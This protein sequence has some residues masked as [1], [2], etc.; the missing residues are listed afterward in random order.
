MDIRK[1]NKYLVFES[2]LLN[3]LRRCCNCGREVEL[4]TF[5]RGTL[6]TV[7]DSCSEGHVL[8]WQSQPLVKRYGSRQPVI[9][10]SYSVLWPYFYRDCQHGSNA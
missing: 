4:N 5:V 1:E 6:L 8:N 7:S 2:C 10:C 3:L 9:I